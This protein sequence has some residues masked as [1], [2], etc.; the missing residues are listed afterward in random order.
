MVAKIA[1]FGMTR[2]LVFRDYYTINK[3]H[4]LPV[5]WLAIETLVT[6]K[7]SPAS[8][9][10][11]LGVVFW[12]ILCTL[13]GFVD[14]SSF[15]CGCVHVCAQRLLSNHRACCWLVLPTSTHFLQLNR[16]P[17][18][19][20]T[21]Y[22]LTA[23][24]L[25][26]PVNA[27]IVLKGH[28]EMPYPAMGNSEVFDYVRQ[29][30]RLR[31][32]PACPDFLYDIMCSCWDEEPEQRPAASTI[33]M[34][35]AERMGLVIPLDDAGSIRTDSLTRNRTDSL[36][37]GRQTHSMGTVHLQKQHPHTQNA[38]AETNFHALSS[39]AGP[40]G[41]PAAAAGGDYAVVT[42]ATGGGIS[43]AATDIHAGD[44]VVMG[45]GDIG[46]AIAVEESVEERPDDEFEQDSNFLSY[47]D[48]ST[49]QKKPPTTTS[50][51]VRRSSSPVYSAHFWSKCGCFALDH[52][53]PPPP[54]RE[55]ATCVCPNCMHI[56]VPTLL[57]LRLW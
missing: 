13:L 29:G 25:L 38:V 46:G 44:G 49:L 48:V 39:S 37:S 22:L 21:A 20:Q 6:S 33:L 14:V 57:P 43:T 2:E 50:A 56:G 16:S 8:D 24:T 55:V 1:D 12:E 36:T 17:H 34:M 23:P 10:W 42:F 53:A 31:K 9:V 35:L 7:F 28:C 5:R 30:N 47:H 52:D 26:L 54:D 19:P 41:L 32:P 4:L 18:A 11:S 45:V 40:A 27:C 51:A 15:E 3:H